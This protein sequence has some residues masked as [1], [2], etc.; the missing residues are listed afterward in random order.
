MRADIEPNVA[1]STFV[2]LTREGL[3]ELAQFRHP[4]RVNPSLTLICCARRSL[5][6]QIAAALVL[7]ACAKT[8][9][10]QINIPPAPPIPPPPPSPVPRNIELALF[11][12]SRVNLDSNN[13]PAPVVVRVLLLRSS[14]AFNAADFF[15]L[16]VQL[17]P[18]ETARLTKPLPG[19]ARVVAALVAYRDLE[20]S[21]WRAIKPLPAAPPPTSPPV[22]EALLVPV[23]V[24]AGERGVR[25][26]TGS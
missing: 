18:G 25:I 23:T 20:R 24:I 7:T 9:P 2:L 11:A 3:V 16:E 21:N 6:L 26:E 17:R 15:A 12:D 4:R 5:C 19:E 10:P 1:T 14:V 13:Q 22:K 8:P